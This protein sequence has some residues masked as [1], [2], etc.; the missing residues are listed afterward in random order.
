MARPPDS[1]IRPPRPARA[2]RRNSASPDRRATLRR[3]SAWIAGAT[4]AVPLA[5]LTPAA[6]L[7]REALP[8]LL[9]GVAVRVQDGDSFLVRAADG[10]RHRIRI[11]GIDAPEKGQPFADAA[12]D[13]LESLVLDRPLELRVSK[14]DPYGRLVAQVH[15]G[16]LD[17]GLA[18]ISAGLAWHFR[19]FAGEQPV[20]LRR[21]YQQAQ[22]RAR[23]ARAGL[24]R[25]EQP[26]EPW[27][28]RQQ[29]RQRPGF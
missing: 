22:A 8:G 20:E 2:C 7:A 23:E 25:Q 13:H 26:M 24:W 10:L 1:A 27:A 9:G 15:N 6:A 28:A 16:Q 3:L 21:Q 4:L 14:T 11:E 17:V 12:R 5:L 18:M 29:A 19:R